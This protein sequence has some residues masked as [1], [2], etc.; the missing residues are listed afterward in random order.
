MI[1]LF[2]TLHGRM[3]GRW[4]IVLGTLK[5]YWRQG[6]ETALITRDVVYFKRSN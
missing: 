5:R 3:A 2:Y 6:K 4:H 1:T